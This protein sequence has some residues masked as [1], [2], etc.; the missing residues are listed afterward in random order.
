MSQ[1]DANTQIAHF[2]ERHA[3]APVMPLLAS[4]R[5]K[6]WSY[7]SLF[8]SL[9]FFVPLILSLPL[10]NAVISFNVLAYTLFVITYLVAINKPQHQLPFYIA[11]ILALGYITTYSNPGGAV[12]FGFVAFICGYYY[13]LKRSLLIMSLVL[14]SLAALQIYFI[15]TNDYFLFAAAIN[16]V[17]L[18]GFGIMERKETLHQIKESQHAASLRTLSAI[19]ERERIGRDLHDVAGHALSSISLKAQLADK[20]LS[21]NNVELAQQ[22]V[23][24]LAELSQSLLSEIR[25]AVSDIKQLSL[26][27]EITKNKALLLE[28]DVSVNLYI[29]D[30]INQHISA[31]E[32]TQLALIVKEL[33]TNTLRY[34]NATHVTLSLKLSQIDTPHPSYTLEYHDFGHLDNVNKIKEGNGLKGMRERAAS[35]NAQAT[36]TFSSHPGFTFTLTSN[37]PKTPLFT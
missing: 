25:H 1:H 5:K 2:K 20:L 6:R 4:G 14:V 7:S 12:F 37:T 30:D 23:R 28:K 33:F 35:I 32:E 31:M 16:S 22:E 21:K 18:L 9:F 15:K 26:T 13:A 17:V 36:M 3:H 34:S 27:D 24:A 19:A 29:D 8:F 11:I 10:G